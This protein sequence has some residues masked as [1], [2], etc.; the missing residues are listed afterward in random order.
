MIGS[1]ATIIMKKWGDILPKLEAVA[2]QPENMV[3]HDQ[4]GK[5]LLNQPMPAD[6]EGN[7]NLFTNRGMGQRLMFEYA[8]SIGVEF[9]FGTR[10]SEYVE[11]ESSAG[12][13]IEG[14]KHSADIIIAADGV[15]SRAREFVTKKPEKPQ[16]S[17]FAVY[18]S[19][20]D[21]KELEEGNPKTD[22]IKHAKKDL[23]E[24]YIGEDIHS[25]VMVNIKMQIMT[26]FV[27]HKVSSSCWNFVKCMF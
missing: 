10:I 22:W 12:I 19:W 14:K 4:Q 3:I 23:M 9:T 13:I 7:P 16:K 17:G 11:D 21:L 5:T 2:A 26:C 24:V 25:I 6:F 15:H 1:N 27:T 8:Q 20:F 18:R